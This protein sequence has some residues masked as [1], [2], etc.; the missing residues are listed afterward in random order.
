MKGM[1]KEEELDE[2]EEKKIKEAE[3]RKKKEHPHENIEKMLKDIGFAQCIPKL[4]EADI[5]DPEIFF[6]LD[7]GTIFS[8]LGIE[9]EGKK[10]RFKERLQ[11]IKEKHEKALA[12]K[13]H[14]ELSEVVG[15]TFEKLQKKVTVVF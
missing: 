11:E 6:E 8:C 10:H 13:E 14:E 2:Q 15:E 9:T 12:K 3:E 1:I 5:S 4:K 7:E